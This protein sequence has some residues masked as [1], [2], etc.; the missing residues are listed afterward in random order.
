MYVCVYVRTYVRTNVRTNVRIYVC[1]CMYACMHVLYERMY[2]CDIC[3]HGRDRPVARCLDCRT[4]RTLNPKPET[5]KPETR[6]PKPQ[7]DLS[8]GVWRVRQFVDALAALELLPQR[9]RRTRAQRGLASK[10][11]RTHCTTERRAEPN[12]PGASGRRDASRRS[13]PSRSFGKTKKIKFTKHDS[14]SLGV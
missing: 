1:V 14:T 8:L 2:M 11:A 9:R 12:V 4:P 5:P 13:G 3:S 10:R 6:N 7:T